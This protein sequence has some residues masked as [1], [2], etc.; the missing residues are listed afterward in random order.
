MFQTIENLF[1]H[2]AA[3]SDFLPLLI[4]L[5][6]FKKS[7]VNL[8]IWI[9]V[10]S[11]LIAILLFQASIYFSQ[12]WT[13]Y[14]IGFTTISEYGLFALFIWLN[15]RS[16]IARK[17]ILF[18]SILFILFIIGY[19]IWVPI[20]V[21]DTI[22]IGIETILILIFSFYFLYERMNE[23]STLLVY[24]DFRFWVVLGMV[25]YLA[26]S[27]FILILSDQM[28]R[29]EFDHYQILTFIFYTLKNLFFTIGIFVHAKEEPKQVNHTKNEIPYLD[30]N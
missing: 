29:K 16:Q 4:F 28:L 8:S 30:I 26:S 3:Y 23:P 12:G 19:F 20:K 22:P 6:F 13:K 17:I 7:K 21:I 14:I 18:T 10:L 2:I 27:F 1:L 9:I 25:L 24:N 11:A 15:I 5:L